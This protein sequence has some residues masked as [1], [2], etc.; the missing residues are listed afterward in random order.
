M[1]QSLDTE[2]S[3][4]LVDSAYQY[5]MD[6]KSFSLKKLTVNVRIPFSAIYAFLRGNPQHRIKELEALK[7]D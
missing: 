5:L 7:I 4:L 6:K 3:L 1:L 2:T